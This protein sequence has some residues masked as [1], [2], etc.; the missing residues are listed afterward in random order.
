MINPMKLLNLP[1]HMT[2]L[3]ILQLILKLH[4]EYFMHFLIAQLNNVIQTTT[5]SLPLLH[6]KTNT[7][8]I[9]MGLKVAS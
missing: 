4:P 6:F 5:Y 7:S 1:M 9:L 8:S 3:I 2:N